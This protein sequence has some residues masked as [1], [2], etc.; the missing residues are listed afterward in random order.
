MTL[1]EYNKTIS[2]MK[3]EVLDDFISDKAKLEL[4]ISSTRDIEKRMQ[5]MELL[6]IVESSIRSVRATRLA[7]TYGEE[8]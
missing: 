8:K 3:N 4:Y 5:Y 6:Q 2:K 1:K 7:K